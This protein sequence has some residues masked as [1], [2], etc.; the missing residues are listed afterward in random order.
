MVIFLPGHLSFVVICGHADAFGHRAQMVFVHLFK[1]FAIAC[2]LSMP[3]SVV[4]IWPYGFKVDAPST[5]AS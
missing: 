5:R 3:I 1:R 4:Q 2:G